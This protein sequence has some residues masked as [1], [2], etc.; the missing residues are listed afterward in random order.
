MYKNVN[1]EKHTRRI[2]KLN[3]LDLENTIFDIPPAVFHSVITLPS[4]DFQKICRDINNLSDFVEIKNVNNQLIISCL[5]DFCCQEIVLS[6]SDQKVV[7]DTKPPEIFQGVFNIKYL[8]LFTK[9]TSLSNTVE[10][11]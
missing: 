8:V 9:C 4:N 6:E 11:Y 5:G 2:T 7:D 1:N 10:L 3:V